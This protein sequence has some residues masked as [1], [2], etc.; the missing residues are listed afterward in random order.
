MINELWILCVVYVIVD[1]NKDW[2]ML[3]YVINIMLFFWIEIFDGYKNINFKYSILFI[4]ILG[5]VFDF[6]IFC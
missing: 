2:V 4:Y 5:I 1:K 3:Y 6:G